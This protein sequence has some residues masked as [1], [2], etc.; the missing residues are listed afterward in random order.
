MKS[1]KALIFIGSIFIVVIAIWTWDRFQ[2]HQVKIKVESVTALYSSEEDAAYRRTNPIKTIKANEKL[3]VK[4]TTYGKD[5]WVLFVETSDGSKGWVD[6][7]QPGIV[8][9]RQK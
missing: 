2:D 4:R 5:Y 8:I 1:K 3:K 7:G 9:V 6:S